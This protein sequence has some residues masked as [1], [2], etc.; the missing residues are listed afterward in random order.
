MLPGSRVTTKGGSGTRLS[1]DTCSGI[2]TKM[3]SG[4]QN[5]KLRER[6]QPLPGS[7]SCKLREWDQ[8]V[9]GSQN[10]KLRVWAQNVVR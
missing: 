2:G 3:L 9:A 10:Y 7:R 8:D 6:D 5:Y 4:D 1:L